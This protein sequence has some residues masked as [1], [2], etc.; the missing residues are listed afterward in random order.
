MAAP[1]ARRDSGPRLASA[2]WRWQPQQ[3]RPLTPRSGPWPARARSPTPVTAATRPKRRS[4]SLV[5]SPRC[6]TADTRGPSRMHTES[7]WWMRTASS[8]RSRAPAGRGS[9]ETAAKRRQPSSTS[10]TRLRPR[11]MEASCSPTTLNN[12]IRK[13]SACG[14]HHDSRRDRWPWFQRRRRPGNQGPDQQPPERRAAPGRRLPDPRHQQP[15]GEEGLFHR[16]RSRPWPATASKGS[17]VTAALR[18]TRGYPCH[19]PWRPRLTA[20]S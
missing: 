5:P 17:Q 18:Q 3:R 7:A 10:F 12:R 11:L 20:A 1:R 2:S 13:I 4:T 8:R 19:L 16:A 9:P 6:P 15:A 14:D